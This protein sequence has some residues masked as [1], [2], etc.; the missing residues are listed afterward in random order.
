[1]STLIQLEQIRDALIERI[2]S[3]LEA[4]TESEG[5]TIEELEEL[6]SQLETEIASK[7]DAISAVIAAKN[8]ELSYLKERRDYFDKMIKSKQ[9]ALERF[10]DYLKRILERREDGTISGKESK[11][12]LVK[13]GGK[14]PLWINP[15][16]DAK[17]LPAELVTVAISYAVS[18]EAM[19]ERLAETNGE[20]MI[21]GQ[22]V[23]KLEPRGTHLRIG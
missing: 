4:E 12:R 11:L 2:I 19:R 6:L 21:D 15:D 16:V 13:N 20:F 10:K 7:V 23:A 5:L 9:N 22:L 18:T 17:S 3:G 8:G 14:Q 1:M